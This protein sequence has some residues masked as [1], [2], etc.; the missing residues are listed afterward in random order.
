M[1]VTVIGSGY[2]QS[3]SVQALSSAMS[4]SNK[5]ICVGNDLLGVALLINDVAALNQASR[6]FIYSF[7]PKRFYL[8]ISDI[9]HGGMLGQFLNAHV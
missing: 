1:N 5:Q 8:Q 9:G 6:E 4:N 2:S 3:T 7:D